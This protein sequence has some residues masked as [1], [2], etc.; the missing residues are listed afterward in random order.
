MKLGKDEQGEFVLERKLALVRDRVFLQLAFSDLF[1]YRQ[2]IYYVMT[3]GLRYFRKFL[4]IHLAN[5]VICILSIVCCA[6]NVLG[7]C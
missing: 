5:S 4:L 6:R 2:G 3:I 7:I 1:N